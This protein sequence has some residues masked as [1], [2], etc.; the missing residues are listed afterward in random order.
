VTAGGGG[1]GQPAVVYALR[2]TA[3]ADVQR[4]FESVLALDRATDWT[5]FRQALS[6]FDAPSQN[7]VYADVDGHIGYQMPGRIP[8]RASGDGSV[9]APGWDG[10]HD[11]TGY[12]PYDQ[13]PFLHD[14]PSGIIATANNAAV[15]ARFPFF[16]GRDWSAGYRAERIIQL[17]EAKPKLTTDDMRVIQGDTLVLQARPIQAALATAKVAPSTADGREVQAL[18]G[19]WDDRCDTSSTGCGP[20][21]LFAYHLLRDVFDPRLGASGKDGTAR[22][23]VGT[24]RSMET[25]IDLLGQPDSRWWDDP[26]TPARETRDAVIAR[27]LDQAGADLRRAFGDPSRWTWGNLHTVTFREPSLGSSGVGPLEAAFDRGPYPVAGAPEAVDQTYMD[28]SVAYPDPYAEKPEPAPGNDAAGLRKLME[29]VAGPS[30]RFVIDMGSLDGATI[31]QTT[32]QSGVPFDAHYGDLIG[33]WLANHDVPLPF[34]QGAVDAA[35]T[36]RLQLRP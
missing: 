15:D 22:L 30:Y 16:I 10:S 11:W 33:D 25:L 31:V 19:P 32:G 20:Y 21:T 14:P 7:V 5:S 35:A 4:T 29:M 1:L 18:I 3:T 6:M 26:S 12:V 17:L 23:F 13:L 2:W 34:T 8:I 36:Q 27:A 28:L 24:E 9:P